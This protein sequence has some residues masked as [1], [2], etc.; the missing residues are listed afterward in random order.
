MMSGDKRRGFVKYGYGWLRQAAPQVSRDRSGA[1]AWGA[2]RLRQ[3]AANRR[4]GRPF[5]RSDERDRF[6]ARHRVRAA[7]ILAVSRPAELA[8]DDPIR[9]GTNEHDPILQSHI[10]VAP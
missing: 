7:S 3:H 10:S 8:D 2:S 6:Q 9:R 4:L 5:L 1:S